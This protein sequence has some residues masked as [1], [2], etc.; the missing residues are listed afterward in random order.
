MMP[1]IT[2]LVTRPEASSFGE[3]WYI[4]IVIRESTIQMA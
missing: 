2:A 4:G 1:K 3:N